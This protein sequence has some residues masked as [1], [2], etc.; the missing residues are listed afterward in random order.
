MRI[1][2][3]MAEYLRKAHQEG[4]EGKDHTF[5]VMLKWLRKGAPLIYIDVVFRALE[6]ACDDLAA[7]KRN[8]RRE[9]TCR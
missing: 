1:T 9:E 3:E 4:R 8:P 6:L 5:P 7:K 2:T